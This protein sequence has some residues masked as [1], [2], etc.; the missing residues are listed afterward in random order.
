MLY[1]VCEGKDWAACVSAVFIFCLLYSTGTGSRLFKH[2]PCL[3]CMDTGLILS[4]SR[5]THSVAQITLFGTRD[6]NQTCC[7][8]SWYMFLLYLLFS[9]SR[10]IYKLQ[11]SPWTQVLKQHWIIIDSLPP[12]LNQWCFSVV[13][14]L[15]ACQWRVLVK[16]QAVYLIGSLWFQAAFC[17]CS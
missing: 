7:F 9:C 3:S 5:F 17:H 13:S 8:Y 12:A 4:K 11:T 2:R 14:A 16:I 10:I 15:R 1:G 6:A